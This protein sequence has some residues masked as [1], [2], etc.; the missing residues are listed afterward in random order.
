M[1]HC[2]E[3]SL[4]DDVMKEAGRTT[5]AHINTHVNTHTHTVKTFDHGKNPISRTDTASHSSPTFQ[6]QDD[7]K[8]V[9]V[10][11]SAKLCALLH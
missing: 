2:Y 8:T 3:E 5:H 7:V 9:C 10:C 1:H 11:A 4:G 6:G